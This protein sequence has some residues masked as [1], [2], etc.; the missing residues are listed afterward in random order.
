LRRELKAASILSHNRIL[1]FVGIANLGGRTILI[2]PFMTN[3]NMLQYLL[4]HPH[5][6]RR[7]PTIQ[8]AEGV[9]FLHDQAGFV[10][11]DLKC[12]NVLVSDH[13]HALVADFGLSTVID[14]EESS[15]TTMTAI[16]ACNTFRFAAPELLLGPEDDG[17]PS[18]DAVRPR[19]KTRESDVY[20]FGMLVLQA[21]TETKPWP[22]LRNEAVMIKVVTGM[23]HPRPGT[24]SSVRG[25]TDDWWSICLSCWTFDPRMRP[26]M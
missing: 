15:A 23:L 22:T 4:E 25:L 24:Q 14:K 2:A 12:E 5:A 1:N 16:R 11:G 21:F 13:G 20:A 19:S 6:D 17:Q 9:H 26:A 8:V 10:H 18:Q 7:A 3:G